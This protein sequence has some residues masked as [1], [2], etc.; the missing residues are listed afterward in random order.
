MTNTI[1]ASWNRIAS[2]LQSNAPAVLERFQAPVT[3]E[4]LDTL[5]AQLNVAL[6]DDFKAFYSIINGTAPDRDSSGI[7]PSCD[8]WDDMAF[9]PLALEQIVQEW[10]MQKELLESGNFVD[11]KPNSSEGIASDWWNVGWIPFADNGGGDYYCV[12]MAPTDAGTKGQIITHSHESGEHKLLATSLTDY[13][14]DLANSLD[15]SAFEYDDDDGIRK[16]KS[17]N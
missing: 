1:L 2:W 5:A 10:E 7:F 14:N 11:L 8:E 12:D 17:D 3:L 4:Q 16:R 13:L 15:A 6:P 9:G